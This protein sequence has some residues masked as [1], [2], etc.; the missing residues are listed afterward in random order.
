MGMRSLL[1]LHLR[2]LILVYASSG[3]FAEYITPQFGKRN[4]E[5]TWM[6]ETSVQPHRRKLEIK[7]EAI[8]ADSPYSYL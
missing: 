5:N 7:Y 4:S 6:I 2:L 3:D 1:G 8:L